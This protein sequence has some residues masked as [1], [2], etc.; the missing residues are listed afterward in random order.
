MPKRLPQL[1]KALPA[2]QLC[3][4]ER[5]KALS[6]HCEVVKFRAGDSAVRIGDVGPPV[7]VVCEGVLALWCANDTNERVLADFVCAQRMAI[8][9]WAL[10]GACRLDLTALTESLAVKI[11]LQDFLSLFTASTAW[12]HWMGQALHHSALRQQA[13]RACSRRAPLELM[14]AQ[15]WWQLAQPAPNGARRFTGR[16]AQQALASHFGVTREEVNR[17]M[18]MLEKAGYIVRERG[19]LTLSPEVAF[20]LPSTSALSDEEA[21]YR[22]WALHASQSPDGPSS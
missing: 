15:T 22:D 17:K 4:A 21:I 7:Y 6:A 16:I 14:L 19:G 8:S 12:A 2:L 11:P 13:Y 1:L 18:K 5:L 20:L 9:T 10:R 3:P